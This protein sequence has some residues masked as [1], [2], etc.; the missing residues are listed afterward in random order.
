MI[1]EEFFKLNLDLDYDREELN[2]ILI[3]F[4]KEKINTFIIMK[5]LILD[6]FYK[7]LNLIINFMECN[8]LLNNKTSKNINFHI[9]NLFNSNLFD[10]MISSFINIFFKIKLDYR[11]L[12]YIEKYLIKEYKQKYNL[13]IPNKL[14]CK[15]LNYINYI[16]KNIILFN[17]IIYN[18]SNLFK[19]LIE[20]NVSNKIITLNKKE[21]DILINEFIFD[22]LIKKC[23]LFIPIKE[24]IYHNLN[25]KKI[26]KLFKKQLCYFYIDSFHNRI[27]H[28]KKAINDFNN[29]FKYIEKKIN[30]SDNNSN[31]NNIFNYNFKN[32]TFEPKNNQED[33]IQIISEIKIKRN[34]RIKFNHNKFNNLFIEL[35]LSYTN[36][37][38]INFEIKLQKI[39]IIFQQLLINNIIDLLILDEI[40][41]TFLIKF[42]KI[43]LNK[44]GIKIVK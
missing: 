13:E 15:N 35:F 16:Y 28:K 33:D 17:L 42:L 40:S 36:K 18:Y 30:N 26:N 39:K 31:N 34:Q 43:F 37:E 5:F 23:N 9:Y 29:K 41:Q 2:E 14:S 8:L 21:I 25:D 32:F 24:K 27:K 19:F 44:E 7:N 20:Y 6:L 38:I 4:L 22:M 11:N 12:F 1:K 3:Y 10:K